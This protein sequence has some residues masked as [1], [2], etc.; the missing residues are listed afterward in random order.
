[1]EPKFIGTIKNGH[2]IPERLPVFKA[3]IQGFEGRQVE[4]VLRKP[5]NPKTLQQLRY[6]HG[7]VCKVIANNTGYTQDEVKGLLK[8]HFLTEYVK[9]PTGKEVPIVPS[10]TDLKKIQ[11]TEFIDQCITLAATHWHIVIPAPNEVNY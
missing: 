2:F 5:Q 4:C 11:M 8:G 3:Y 10:L 9:G 7:V 6:F 1:M